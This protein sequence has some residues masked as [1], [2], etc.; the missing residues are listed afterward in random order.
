[1]PRRSHFTCV[2]GASCLDHGGIAG[3]TAS[4]SRC[5][6]FLRA[7]ARRQTFHCQESAGKRA[8]S[9]T[10]VVVDRCVSVVCLLVHAVSP[11][12]SSGNFY[13]LWNLNAWSYHK[14]LVEEYGD[15][16]R[17]HGLLGVRCS[18]CFDPDPDPD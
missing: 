13:D 3:S 17:I 10:D 2:K 14:E 12:P 5:P 11:L 7:L 6:R 18:A 8:R 4:W 16:V 15:A 1:M 9:F